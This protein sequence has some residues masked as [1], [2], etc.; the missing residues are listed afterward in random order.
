M[1]HPVFSALLLISVLFGSPCLLTACGSSQAQSEKSGEKK[2]VPVV[3]AVAK[4]QS[5]P[6]SVQTTGVVQAYATVSVKSQIAGQLVEVY[7]KEGQDV[8]QGDRLFTI[9]PRLLEANLANAIAN[10]DKA[11]AQVAQAQAQ[12][13]QAQAQVLQAQANVARDVAQA[14]NATRQAERYTGLQKQGVISQNQAEQFTSTAESQQAIVVA[15][16]SNVGN[17]IAAVDSAEA[18][19]E[20]AR[21]ALNS[22][23]AVV[24]S[25]RVQLTYTAIFA[26][27]DGRV[28]KLNVDRGNLVKDN[29][30]NPLV[31][32]SQITP[33]YVEFSVPQRLLPEI[34]KYQAQKK[35]TVEANPPQD[36]G[37]PAQGE[38]VFVDSTVDAAT[39]TI[40][41]KAQFAN[42][43]KQ[44]TPGQFVNVKLKL[45][46]N[47]NAIAV[48]KTA[49]QTG[50]KG[51]FVYTIKA[52][53]TVEVRPVTVGAIVNDA[54][55]ITKGLED[56]ERVVIDGQFNL[57]PG[58]LV[59]EQEKGK[60]EKGKEKEK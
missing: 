16:Q 5:I 37:K 39:G 1:R 34:K 46:E 33:I 28:G 18:N 38:L 50:Q 40:K 55:V 17:A 42:P 27:I 9:D 32:I 7:F 23:D 56:G 29:D 41:L 14:K 25:V 57:S 43:L 2:A 10:R 35:L 20:N 36:S 58:A 54:I 24:E 19:L 12:V 22:A 31:V 30:T 6:L 15:S 26:P 13:G 44:L 4:R 52:D 47:P 3:S 45:T 49:I 8:S 51:T 48:P 11:A 59:K 21:A 53:Q 60:E